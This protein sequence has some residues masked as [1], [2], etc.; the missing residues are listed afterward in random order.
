MGNVFGCA[1]GEMENVA[2]KLL[3]SGNDTGGNGM[4]LGEGARINALD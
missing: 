1:V 4:L 3:I 2:A